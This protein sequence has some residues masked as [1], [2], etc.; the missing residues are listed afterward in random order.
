MDLRNRRPVHPGFLGR[1][2][3]RI[4]VRWWGLR[5]VP[6]I[7][8]VSEQQRPPTPTPWFYKWPTMGEIMAGVKMSDSQQCNVTVTFADRRGNPASV[9][10]VPEWSTDNTDVLALEPSGDGKSCLVKAVGPL[11]TATVTMKA[12]ADMGQGSTPVIGTLDFEIT[13]GA[14]TVVKLEPGT[15]AEQPDATGGGST[16]PTP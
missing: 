15:P 8:P 5:I 4:R 9:D 3:Y 16:G 11:G 6:I 14:A 2:W 13:G 10:G 7:G 1:L 12:D